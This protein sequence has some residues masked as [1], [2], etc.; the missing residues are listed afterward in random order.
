ME[1][2]IFFRIKKEQKMSEIQRIRQNFEKDN[3]YLVPEMMSREKTTNQIRNDFQ[4]GNE[5]LHKQVDDKN[6]IFNTNFH[7]STKFLFY[8]LVLSYF[9]F[10]ENTSIVHYVPRLSCFSEV[11]T[12]QNILIVNKIY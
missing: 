5:Y 12:W 6:A 9:N 10:I 1:R 3:D 8:F 2:K 11:S 7:C 4:E